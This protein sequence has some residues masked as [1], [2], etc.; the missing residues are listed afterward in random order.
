M[1]G[2]I[3]GFLEIDRQER[4]YKPASDRIRHY[5]E[6]VIPLSEDQVSGQAARC[7]DCGIPFCH[8]GCPVNNRTG[9][10]LFTRMN[11]RRL[12]STCILQITFLNLPGG[13]ARRPARRR[14]R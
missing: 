5:D 7:M 13:F 10:I 2:K 6:F 9:M 12:R 11:G 1:M 3:T 8:T 14:A 4:S